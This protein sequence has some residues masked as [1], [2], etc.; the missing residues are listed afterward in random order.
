MKPPMEKNIPTTSQTSHRIRK[1]S[2]P[3][4]F[5]S[6]N[7]S[8]LLG[9]L[10]GLAVFSLGTNH[11][12]AVGAVTPFTTLEAEDGTLSGGAVVS[13]FSPG[14]TVP[15]A[16]TQQLEASGMAFVELNNTGASVLWTNPVDGA[17]AIVIRSSI[18]DAASG[19]GITATLDLYVNG[20]FR[21]TITLSSHQSW[22]YR[23]NPNAPDNPS[24][25]TPWIFYN[26][27]HAFITGTPIASGST[28]TLQRDSGNTATYYY[29]DCIDLENVPPALTQPANS[30]S[31]VSYG[32]DPTGLLDSSVAISNCVVAAEAA[33]E[34][35]WMPPG[36]YT[37]ASNAS[38][39]LPISGI[40][41]QGAGMWYTTMF[42]NVPASQFVLKSP[43]R[44]T[45][46]IT[47][48]TV[49]QDFAIDSDG[50]FRTGGGTDYA[51][52]A[53]GTNWLIQRVWARHCGPFWLGGSYSTI[54]DCRVGF[55]WADGINLNDGS[56]PSLQSQ[57]I[58]LTDSNNFVRG[59]GDDGLSTYSDAG[60]GGNNY[61]MQG[62]KIVNSSS[63][64]T[65]WA[66]GI[67]IG[68]GTNVLVQGCLVDSVAANSG[69]EVSVYGNTG[70]PL[71][72][73]LVSGNTVLRAGG[74]N[75]SIY[76]GIHVGAPGSASGELF[77]GAFT[78]AT[79]AYNTID[80]ALR[81][82]LAI[83]SSNENLSV[84]ANQIDNPALQ[85][86]WV[87][88]GVAGT[89][90]FDNNDVSGLNS[91][92]PM[93]EN[94]SPTKFAATFKTNSARADFNGDGRDDY[95]FFNPSDATWHITY[96]S[97][98]T[99][100][101]F[102]FG[103]PGDVPL[104][105]GNWFGGGMADAVVFTPSTATWSIRETLT[106]QTRATYVFGDAGD[107]PLL[108]TF[109]DDGPDSVVWNPTTFHWSVRS[110]K[111]GSTKY[112]FP[113]GQ[114]DDIP[115]MNGDFDGD[116]IPDAVIFRPSNNKW[117]IWSTGNN[118]EIGSSF[119]FGTTGCIP[120]LGGDYDGDGI[121]D[122]QYFDPA[123]D[124][125]HIHYSKDGSTHTVSSWGLSG[126][127]PFTGY[128]TP[129]YVLD[130]NFYR[131]STG[132]FYVRDITTGGT[133]SVQTTG[134]SASIPVH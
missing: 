130:Q 94:D 31:I 74:W 92:E 100:N 12:P 113:W 85:G 52:G 127:I 36:T 128:I 70:R 105:D 117:Y 8:R 91:G 50:T 118:K 49:L 77:P 129:D 121:P 106:G 131:P 114:A 109:P 40:T 79:I 45:M 88:T 16:P 132:F 66:N 69:I 38:W 90:L 93:F 18:P 126:D 5:V 48:N 111:D 17:N 120:V 37:V 104:V 112:D 99:T 86:I 64:A 34:I 122:V 98:L 2:P 10:G 123:T 27:D 26:E 82:G 101:S 61:Q 43:W 15:T 60:S 89:G 56:N 7:R 87:M 24:S 102:Q 103:S 9:L 47:T 96:S 28:I 42:R 53:V 6:R 33:N 25:G 51:C 11:A 71:D 13:A 30:L 125:W 68:G 133:L 21:Q 29:I 19:G 107:F 46:S 55:S 116:G 78:K 108:D 14:Q 20:A 84:V 72:S 110:S 115:L 67:R 81:A 1:L 59:C 76:G 41:V 73:A 4:D 3:F 65:Y 75:G 35:V 23:G 22:N 54:R 32:A 58:S 39:V 134:T 95:V 83:G 80:Y 124:S 63:I 44:S 119:V 57:G 97:N 62:T